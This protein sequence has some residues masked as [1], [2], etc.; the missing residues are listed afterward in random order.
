MKKIMITGANGFLGQHLCRHFIDKGDKVLATGKGSSRLGAIDVEYAELDITNEGAVKTYL[1]KHAPGVVIHT[2]AMS[3][4][5][6]CENHRQQCWEVN[7]T[8]TKNLA[9]HT[10][11]HFIFTSTDFVFGENG[12]HAEEDETG[13]LNYYGRSKLEAEQQV[14]ANSKMYSI[15]RPV[16]IY[17]A[18]WDGLRGSFVQWV[19]QN[20]EQGKKIKVV[21]DQ[22]R[23]PTYVGDICKGISTMIDKP[24]TGIFHL[25]G[26]DVLSP[27]DMAI[28]TARVLKLDES[29]IEKVTADTF[30]EPVKRAKRS[31]LKIDK[32]ITELNYQPV[33]F[34][35]GVRLTFHN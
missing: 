17:G 21:S 28:A 32:A 7:V 22:L 30:P 25:A 2:A 14:V 24:A 12:P 13:P 1:Q 10:Q 4:P 18:A 35:E 5:D 23:T 9:T 29:L 15:V 6:G 31:G 19:K 11:G 34:E 27:Y 3:K 26:K 20:L 33:S 8:A 16:F